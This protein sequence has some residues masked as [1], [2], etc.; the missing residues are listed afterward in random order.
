MY[1]RG[2][3][4]RQE[5]GLEDAYV[6][7]LRLLD[8]EGARAAPPTPSSVRGAGGVRRIDRECVQAQPAA[9]PCSLTQSD[10]GRGVRDP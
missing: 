10:Q 8:P 7:G 1:V 9:I 4:V 6:S 3:Y 2:I 5:S